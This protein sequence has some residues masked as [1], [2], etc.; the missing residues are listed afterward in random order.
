MTVADFSVRAMASLAMCH[1][2]DFRKR[3]DF[4][5]GEKAL[6]LIDN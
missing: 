6:H 3:H 1:W 4:P 2:L 5:S